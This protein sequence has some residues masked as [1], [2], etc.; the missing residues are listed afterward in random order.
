MFKKSLKSKNKRNRLFDKISFLKKLLIK[1]PPINTS[2][3][4]N[5]LVSN[6]EQKIKKNS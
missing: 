4:Y 1:N 6:F 3:N 5:E 2:Q